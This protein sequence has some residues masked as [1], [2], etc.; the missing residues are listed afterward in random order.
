VRRRALRFLARLH[1]A[2]RR[3]T[4]PSQWLARARLLDGQPDCVEHGYLELPVGVRAFRD[5]NTSAA[6]AGVGRDAAYIAG[7]I[8]SRCCGARAA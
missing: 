1:R 7:A 8:K 6:A 2:K 3:G 5:G 4:C